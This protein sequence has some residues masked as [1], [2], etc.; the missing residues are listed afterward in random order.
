MSWDG[1]VNSAPY[2]IDAVLSGEPGKLIAKTDLAPT[3]HWLH[4]VKLGVRIQHCA[5][6]VQ[7]MQLGY[8]VTTHDTIEV[9]RQLA[10]EG[11]RVAP[12]SNTLVGY[13]AFSMAG[14]GASLECDFSWGD[15]WKFTAG[16]SQ[17][18]LSQFRFAEY[19]GSVGSTGGVNQFTYAYNKWGQNPYVDPNLQTAGTAKARWLNARVA[20]RPADRPWSMVLE[21]P[22][23]A[24]QVRAHQTPSMTESLN[25]TEV[26]G[27]YHNNSNSIASGR[28]GNQDVQHRLPTFW[29][30]EASY[31]V[32]SE[33]APVYYAQGVGAMQ[34]H[35]LGNRWALGEGQGVLDLMIEPKSKT[36][37]LKGGTTRWTLGL[38]I[39]VSSADELRH[40][41]LLQWH[42]K[43]N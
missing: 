16:I 29:G 20:W 2:R 6:A 8:A 5:P 15:S 19:S 25:L 41:L 12:N 14:V 32:S 33:W 10:G 42:L 26:N 1:L 39:G 7:Q 9:W 13:R 22:V 18:D 43:Y 4:S 37:L 27:Q 28:Y 3:L 24:G 31:T 36:V 35:F 38:G 40:P 23:L 17:S 21:L 11:Y 30:L 34:T